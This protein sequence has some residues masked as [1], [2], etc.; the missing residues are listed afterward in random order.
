MYR[1]LC[2]DNCIFIWQIVQYSS[3]HL[4]SVSFESICCKL[5]V[6]NSSRMHRHFLF[7]QLINLR[8][9]R[10][11]FILSCV[12][13]P[14]FSELIDCLAFVSTRVC[15]CQNIKKCRKIQVFLAHLLVLFYYQYC[16]LTCYECSSPQLCLLKMANSFCQQKET[17][18]QHVQNI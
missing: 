11:L 18:V 1:Q 14:A 5:V 13:L 17:A 10:H 8:L 2:D 9:G 6:S 7:C 16:Y 4:F 3:I 12:I 15:S